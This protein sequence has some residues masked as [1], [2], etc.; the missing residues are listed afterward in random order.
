MTTSSTPKDT[1]RH[2]T[3]WSRPPRAIYR[4]ASLYDGHNRPRRWSLDEPHSHYRPQRQGLDGPQHPLMPHRRQGRIRWAHKT[5]VTRPFFFNIL[6]YI[7]LLL[8]ALSWPALVWFLD[9]ILSGQPWQI[10]LRC[11]HLV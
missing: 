8:V 5:K 4:Q 7:S 11:F 10:P 6:A 1:Q 9:I 2:W 3:I